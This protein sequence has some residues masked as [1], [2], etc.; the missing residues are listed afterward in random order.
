MTN[1]RR[2]AVRIALIVGLASTSVGCQTTE[3][4]ERGRL[5]DPIMALDEDATENHFQQKCFY[6][7]EGSIGGIG[8]SAGGGCGCY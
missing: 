2:R 4:F 8:V 3:F 6:S 7:R 5:V 1:L